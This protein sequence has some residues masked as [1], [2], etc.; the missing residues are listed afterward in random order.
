MS[1][2]TFQPKYLSLTG[3]GIKPKDF[4]I[5]DLNLNENDIFND[6]N[7]FNNNLNSSNEINNINTLSSISTNLI[8]HSIIDYKNSEQFDLK[9]ILLGDAGVGK[10]SIITKFTTNQFRSGYHAT[11]GVEF[12][13]KEIYIDPT[14]YARLKI[15]DTCGQEKFRSITRQY[16]R[17]TNGVLLIFDLT[18]KETLSKLN[19]WLDD[20]KKE[21]DD[22]CAIFLIGNKM[23]I[24]D[25][26][27]TISE[28]AKK[29]ALKNKIHY[30]EVS[31][32]TGKG[33]YTMFE[34]L[35]KKMIRMIKDERKKNE[36]GGP[37]NSKR[38]INIDDYSGNNE[39]GKIEQKKTNFRCC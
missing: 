5:S 2:Y 31:A 25:R 21:I 17:G 28:E 33:I 12:K 16:Y 34:K 32:K 1:S 7:S 3:S 11:L 22:D 14:S 18:C 37:N 4:L 19:L 36:E 35:G 9:V 24:K 27:L 6:I 8:H 20:I 26:D 13:T 30:L 15:W 23:D 39:R 38:A 29:Y 10:T